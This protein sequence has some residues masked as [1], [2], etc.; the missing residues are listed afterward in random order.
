MEIFEEF[1][2][3]SFNS[4]TSSTKYLNFDSWHIPIENQ[5]IWQSQSS[6]NGFSNSLHHRMRNSYFVQ[7]L[8]GTRFWFLRMT[9]SPDPC[10][11][12]RV[13]PEAS[14]LFA[15]RMPDLSSNSWWSWMAITLI[16]R[17]TTKVN[18]LK[19]KKIQLKWF[20]SWLCESGQRHFLWRYQLLSSSV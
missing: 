3:F 9:C 17:I 18:S 10:S 19:R 11:C 20:E 6:D 8:Q 14:L 5:S 15:S 1:L 2:S 12:D 7:S 13:I 4:S 16:A